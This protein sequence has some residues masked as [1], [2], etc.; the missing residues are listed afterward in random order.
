M[1]VSL[2]KIFMQRGYYNRAIEVLE[3]AEEIL[4]GFH[5]TVLAP[6]YANLGATWM[7]KGDY[8]K[9]GRYL[10]DWKDIVERA[11][12]MKSLAMAVG[13]IGVRAEMMGEDRKVV[14][15]CRLQAKLAEKT[16]QNYLLAIACFNLGN[17]A[18]AEK[19]ID[20]AE[21]YFTKDMMICRKL[22]YRLGESV[23]M[24]ALS[25][26]L[27]YRGMFDKAYEYATFFVTVSRVLGNRYRELAALSDLATVHMYSG[28]LEQA[29]K[30]L[31]DRML[32]AGRMEVKDPVAETFFLQAILE[33]LEEKFAAALRSMQKVITFS[34]ENDISLK[35]RH[36]CVAG[37]LY[38]LS[39]DTST[40]EGCLE[41]LEGLLK[42]N[43]P[44]DAGLLDG[45]VFV[46]EEIGYSSPVELVF[47]VI[48]KY[49]TTGN[50]NN[51]K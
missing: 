42:L 46:L 25:T 36:Y 51:K 45:F 18:L 8:S 2:G 14:E 17:I 19:D 6:V 48:N 30:T 49:N 23:A 37:V 50:Q 22:G 34:K 13:T 35:P 33:L 26:I 38:T 20:T 7:H 5:E 39:G 21:S 43:I 29:E 31:E 27:C 44:S 12:D 9:A 3:E 16:G 28:N 32:V 4:S 15:Y 24:G 41:R 40:G 11:G 1:R 47:R 10:H